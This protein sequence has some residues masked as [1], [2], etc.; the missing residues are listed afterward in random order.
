MNRRNECDCKAQRRL[1]RDQRRQ[2]NFHNAPGSLKG[3]A[4]DALCILS[5]S[6]RGG[7]IVSLLPHYADVMHLSLQ[8]ALKERAEWAE[9]V[10]EI[11]RE[12]MILQSWLSWLKKGPGTRIF[13]TSDYWY[14]EVFRRSLV[15]SF[16]GVWGFL[17]CRVFGR[18]T[19]F[20]NRVNTQYCGNNTTL[21]SD[22][23]VLCAST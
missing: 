16:V 7:N 10:W 12:Q 23:L 9:C 18:M 20:D 17:L 11:R 2:N 3:S 1:L 15:G 4:R 13:M 22:L 21:E 14:N 8:E 6:S 5:S 19:E